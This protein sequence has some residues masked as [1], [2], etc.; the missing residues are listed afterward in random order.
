VGAPAFP[1]EHE[2]P[3]TRRASPGARR[4]VR[5]IIPVG[6]LLYFLISSYLSSR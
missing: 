1:P 4:L 5:L 2:G 3:T 6:V